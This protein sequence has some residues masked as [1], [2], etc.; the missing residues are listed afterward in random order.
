MEYQKK[1]EKIGETTSKMPDKLRKIAGLLDDLQ[2][3]K[4]EIEQKLAT[5]PSDELAADLNQINS[6]ITAADNQLCQKIDTWQGNKARLKANLS[7]K[8]ATAA[9]TPAAEPGPVVGSPEIPAAPAAS[10]PATT[11]AAGTPGQPEKKKSNGGAWLFFGV[12][13]LVVTVGAVN[14][15]NNKS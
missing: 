10:V 7:K 9:G 8:G 5:E 3:V 15:F 4:S 6:E 13:A 1:L 2:A 14:V 11:T 12:L